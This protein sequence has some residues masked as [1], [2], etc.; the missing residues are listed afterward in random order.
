MYGRVHQIRKR[1]R[2][3]K[4]GFLR[5]MIPVFMNPVG[6]SVRCVL[7]NDY[8]LAMVMYPEWQTLVDGLVPRFDRVISRSMSSYVCSSENCPHAASTTIAICSRKGV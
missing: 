5:I 8:F 4:R 6:I 7:K 3:N 1:I 2:L